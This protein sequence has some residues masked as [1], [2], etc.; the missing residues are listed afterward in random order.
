MK[1]K[2]L[3]FLILVIFLT[4]LRAQDTIRN[5][6][7]SE[8]RLDEAHECYFELTN[9]G[10]STLHLKNFE[11]GIVHPLNSRIDVNDI[12]KWF[13]VDPLGHF[14]LPDWTLDPGK[15][16]VVAGVYDYNPKMWLKDQDHFSQAITK[17][18]MWKLANIQIH[19]AEAE[20]QPDPLDSV[21]PH[22]DVMGSW[23]GRAC[24]Y[25]RHHVA[26][27]DSV[28][29]DQVGGVF[30]DP[31]GQQ[32]WGGKDVAGVTGATENDILVRKFS[33]K[34]GNTDFNTGRGTTA[35]E[36]EWIPIPI[37][38][39]GGYEPFRAVLWTV[40]N[41]VNQVLSPSTLVP[42]SS[43]MLVN[44]SDSTITVPW[45]VRNDDSIMYQ[46]VRKPG[47]GWHY[48]YV[49]S[50]QDSAYVS[51]RT[52]DILTIYACGNVGTVVPF[53]LNVS[54]ATVD[55]AIVVPKKV[56]DA[57]GTYVN[58]GAFCDVTDG[59]PGMDTIR[60]DV[61]YGIA[62]ATSVDTLLKYL[63]KAP[64]A[65]WKIVFVD[66]VTRTNL[67]NGDILEVAAED[68]ITVKNYFIKVR[69]YKPSHNAELAS[70]TW[71]D[72]PDNYRG[73]YGW[74]DDKISGYMSE[75]FN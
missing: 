34:T 7:F 49:K 54:P 62:F 38:V 72:I 56:A 2:I 20:I 70:I 50:H 75:K 67:K 59:V 71:P 25:I 43:A 26:P 39:P 55:A 8:A 21:T 57:H 65:S 53:T 23:Q 37:F 48:D 1:T 60:G 63:E 69:G 4:S 64:N 46:F 17:P 35:T 11:L 36:S 41:H 52:G 47:M 12:G 73:S 9:M 45:G 10:D 51:V 40:G 32:A 15:S 33:V 42:K 30:T 66:G 28:I 18:E 5:L 27:G 13:N 3:L 74:Q 14:M 29:V 68:A 24:W 6:I 61:L 16:I 19:F 44:F 22:N 31:N 58:A